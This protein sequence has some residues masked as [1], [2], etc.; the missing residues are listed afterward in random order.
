MGKDILSMSKYG[1]PVMMPR[2]PE[3][4]G[5]TVRL[6]IQ[7]DHNGSSKTQTPLTSARIESSH[8]IPQ[9]RKAVMHSICSALGASSAKV[10]QMVS[11]MLSCTH[12]VMAILEHQSCQAFTDVHLMAIK[13]AL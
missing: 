13:G 1:S 11:I 9:E 8:S 6:R 5:I 7:V 3:L 10:E 2:C 12:R 4:A